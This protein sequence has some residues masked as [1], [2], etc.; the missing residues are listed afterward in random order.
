M[1]ERGENPV[2]GPVRT[3]TAPTVEPTLTP[4]GRIR[5][6]RAPVLLKRLLT[7]LDTMVS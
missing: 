3:R 1:Q 7:L 2:A 6:H 5:H 4:H